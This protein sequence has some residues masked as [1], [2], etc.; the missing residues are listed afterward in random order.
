MKNFYGENHRKF[1]ILNLEIRRFDF[2]DFLSILSFAIS[3]GVLFFLN[4][5]D[6]KNYE[7]GLILISFSVFFLIVL[8]PFGLRFRN[9]YFSIIWLLFSIS[10]LITKN[11]VSTIP[12][13][14]FLLYHIIRLI[15]WKNYN[16]EFIPYN[17]GI[18]TFKIKNLLKLDLSRYLSK[19][20][21]RGGYAEDKIYMTYFVWLGFILFL[22]IFYISISYFSFKR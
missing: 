2:F 14:I 1:T 6:A 5:L 9:F 15:F 21:G 19:I 22:L 12:I 4:N 16:M 8:T 10:L 18:S 17:V 20:E 3:L 7:I 13:V 11:P